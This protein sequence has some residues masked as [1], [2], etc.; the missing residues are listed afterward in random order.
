[1][2]ARYDSHSVSAY[3]PKSGQMEMTWQRSTETKR[4]WK[5]ALSTIDVCSAPKFNGKLP[6][7]KISQNNNFDLFFFSMRNFSKKHFLTHAGSPSSSFSFLL[8]LNAHKIRVE[9]SLELLYYDLVVSI[10][11]TDYAYF[12]HH[13][14]NRPRRFS[15]MWEDQCSYIMLGFLF[16]FSD[17]T[18]SKYIISL[19]YNV[20][21]FISC[22]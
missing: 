7:Q 21:R 4:G 22:V 15:S 5:S 12:V 14:A 6:I 10:Y 9:L 2:G 1:M 3:P 8:I 13:G 20:Q 18:Y 11:D 19:W 16:K 17:P